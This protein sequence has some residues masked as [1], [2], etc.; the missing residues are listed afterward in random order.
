MDDEKRKKVF[1]FFFVFFFIFFLFFILQV[2]KSVP[3]QGDECTCDFQ[4]NQ[5][6]ETYF[7]EIQN[8]KKI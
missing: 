2:L 4:K 3:Y 6:L 7:L 8:D 5:N 1:G